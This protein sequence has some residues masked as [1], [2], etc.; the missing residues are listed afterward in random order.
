MFWQRKPSLSLKVSRKIDCLKEGITDTLQA[1]SAT[2]C[3]ESSRL[4][5]GTPFISSFEDELDV[6]RVYR[7]G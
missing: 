7:V 2:T 3:S 4:V 6:T 1:A 5:H